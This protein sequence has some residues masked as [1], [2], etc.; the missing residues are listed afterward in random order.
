[1]GYFISIGLLIVLVTLMFSLI[2]AGST[3]DLVA[4]LVAAILLF[5]FLRGVMYYYSV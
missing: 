5:L 1:M 4:I 2:W 3:R